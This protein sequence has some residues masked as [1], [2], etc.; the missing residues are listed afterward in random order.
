MSKYLQIKNDNQKR[1]DDFANDNIIWIIAM[2]EKKFNDELTSR[3]LKPDDVVSVGHGAFIKKDN[4][5]NYI[6][7]MHM[8]LKNDAFEQVKNDDVE[9]KKAFIYELANHE[10][11]ITYELDD[12]LDALGTTEE[13]IKK[14]PR[15]KKILKEAIN[16]YLKNSDN[17]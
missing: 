10:Y 12:T 9:V 2:T 6:E 15:L 7:Y 5:N 14:D 4:Y 8:L 17:L 11:C 13:E 3:G 1:F 16:E